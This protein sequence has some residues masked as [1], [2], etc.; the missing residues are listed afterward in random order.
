MD[1]NTNQN[2]NQ[3]APSTPNAKPYNMEPHI[4]AAFAY[5]ISP[6]TG[7]LVLFTEKQNAFVRFHAMQSVIFGIAAIV[8][9]TVCSILIPFIIGALLL[10]FVSLAFFVMWLLLMWNAYNKKE[11][12]LP[13]IGKIARDQ[14][15]KH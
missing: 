8:S 7:F 3:T 6:I 14:L 2:N 5:L 10:P 13:Y 9:Y 11:Y 1:Q 15:S 12:E 4:E